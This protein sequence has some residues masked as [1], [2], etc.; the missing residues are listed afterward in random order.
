MFEP[1][2]PLPPLKSPTE[3]DAEW[4]AI[5]KKYGLE[6]WPVPPSGPRLKPPA[7]PPP[8]EAKRPADPEPEAVPDEK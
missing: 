6:E 2:K 7:A 1:Y 4:E 8:R 5:K 3:L